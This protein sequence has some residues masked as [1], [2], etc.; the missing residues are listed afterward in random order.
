MTTEARRIEPQR[1]EDGHGPL[2]ERDYWA[3]IRAPSGSPEELADLVARRFQAFA[4]PSLVRF[5]RPA[6]A[7]G[8]LEVGDEMQV[9]IRAAGTHA[10]RVIHRDARSLT[11]VTLSGHPEAGRI[12]FGAY[13]N[14]RGDVLFHI[15]SRARAA[16]RMRL[17][18]FLVAGDP[19]QTNTWTDFINRVATTFGD[20]VRGRVHAEKRTVEAEPG[21]AAADRPTFCTG[22]G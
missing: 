22:E 21:D 7:D 13:R 18:G 11:V 16:S 9:R 17:L 2:L 19:M 15:R 5:L 8:P 14:G 6:D 3:V 20:G 12:T 10:V 1:A 4:P